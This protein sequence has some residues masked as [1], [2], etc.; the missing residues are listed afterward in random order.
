MSAARGRGTLP[1]PG[2]GVPPPAARERAGPA[3]DAPAGPGRAAAVPRQ[4]PPGRS[5]RKGGTAGVGRVGATAS[6]MQRP[7]GRSRCLSATAPVADRCAGPRGSALAEPP[8]DL[9]RGQRVA[10]AAGSA[11]PQQAGRHR[12]PR[13][14]ARPFRRP[15][16]SRPVSRTAAGR[17]TPSPGYAPDRAG[18]V[19]AAPAEPP[20][21]RPTASDGS[22]PP[23]QRDRIGPGGAETPVVRAR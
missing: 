1:A 15:G 21:T 9:D 22:P 8:S 6:P 13:V 14:R 17:Q 20:G 23:R 19:A 12:A 18:R 5:H 11:V 7:A 4:A 3:G 16:R 10:A 2:A